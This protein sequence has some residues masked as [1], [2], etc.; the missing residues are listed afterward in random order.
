M[1]FCHQRVLGQPFLTQQFSAQI[2]MLDIFMRAPAMNLRR[3]AEYDTY[4][5]QHRRFLHEL[6]VYQS[7][8]FP[9]RMPVDD[10]QRPIR[11][12]PTVRHQDMPQLRNTTV[13]LVYERVII[14]NFEF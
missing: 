6:P 10:R 9:F 14:R 4:I 2:A 13:V 5:V 8:R 1:P 12:L 3:I 11:H 7:V